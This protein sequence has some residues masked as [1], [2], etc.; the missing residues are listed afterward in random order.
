MG[1]ESER[2]MYLKFTSDGKQL[3][4]QAAGAR[5]VGGYSRADQKSWRLI[6]KTLIALITEC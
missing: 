6:A 5:V 2:D 1:M 4:S 3:I